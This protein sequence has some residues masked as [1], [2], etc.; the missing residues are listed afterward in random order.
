MARIARIPAVFFAVPFIL[1]FFF[2]AIDSLVDDSPTMDEQ[3]HVARGLAFLKTGDPRLSL[4]HPPLINAIS[5]L[6]LLTEQNINLP[7]DHPSWEERQGWYA[8][9]DELFWE[10]DNDPTR[11]IFL[12]RIPIIFLT[13]TLALTGF[14]FAREMWGKLAAFFAFAI[15]LLEPNL[16]AVKRS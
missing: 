8:F 5:A 10:R 15:L 13:L 1:L 14:H 11:M 9:A 16:L 2:L 12:A 4:E 6:P 7:T 3:N